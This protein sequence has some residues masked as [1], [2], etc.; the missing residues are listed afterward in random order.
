MKFLYQARNKTGEFKKGIVTATSQAKA[1]QLLTDNGLIIVSLKEEKDSVFKIFDSFTNRIG[2]KD[3]VLFSR[4]FSTLVGARVPI[5]QSL[6][7]LQSQVSN[8]GLVTVTKSL[9]QSVESGDSL[10]NALAKHPRVFGNIYISL[11]RAGEASGK[12]A[13]SLN[14]LADQLEKD[15]DLRSKVKAAMTYP[16]FVLSALVL[17]GMLMFKFVLPNLVSVLKEQNAQL[18]LVSK[19]L[20][21]FTDFFQVYWW[22]VILAAIGLGAGIRYYIMTSA[23]RYEWDKFKMQLP[24]MGSILERIYLARFARNLATL[25]AGGIPIIQ[26]L[27]IIADIINN[28]VYRDILL[29]VAQQVTNG[30]SI[31]DSL[32][33]YKQFP[34]LVTQMVRVGEQTAQLDSILLKLATFYEKEVDAK[35]SMLSSLLEPI[36]MLVLGLGVGILVAG[37]L[38][39]IYNLASAV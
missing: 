25:V 10:S 30:K 3:L 8:K 17:V 38:L 5:V 22:M 13:E 14:Y 12:V 34:P 20:I 39:P 36:I 21:A 1:E 19:I 16:A 18:P 4:Q 24:V 15:Y 32:S 6:R 33:K 7:I 9:V 26:A 29:E 11:V 31:G 35:V 23:G 28:V 2:Y 27:R 37:V